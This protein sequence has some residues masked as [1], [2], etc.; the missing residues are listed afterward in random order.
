[1][2][3]Q[4][5]HLFQLC[6]C[7]TPLLHVSCGQALRLDASHQLQGRVRVFVHRPLHADDERRAGQDAHHAQGGGGGGQEEEGG[8]G[9][10]GGEGGGTGGSGQK[11]EGKLGTFFSVPV[12]LTF[13]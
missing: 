13:L 10:G 2:L 9:G 11:E 7:H 3:I 12:E 4:K 5:A 8:G 1:M 6:H